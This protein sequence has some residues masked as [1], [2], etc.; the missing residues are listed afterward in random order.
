M[1]FPPENGWIKQLMVPS[2][3]APPDFSNEIINGR[4]SRFRRS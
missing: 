1:H 4:V 3:S 2:E